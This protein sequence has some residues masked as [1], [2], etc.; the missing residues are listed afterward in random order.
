LKPAG[1][2]FEKEHG[3]IYQEPSSG[4]ARRCAEKLRFSGGRYLFFRGYAAVA[5]RERGSD[6]RNGK[7]EL[8]RTSSGRAATHTNL[9]A[10]TH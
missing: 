2:A 7:A 10:A 9:I 6:R 1:K 3:Q 8:F 4:F 5:K